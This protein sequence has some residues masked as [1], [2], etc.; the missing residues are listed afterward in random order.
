MK[1]FM[2]LFLT[3]ICIVSLVACGKKEENV[4]VNKEGTIYEVGKDITFYYPS[5]FELTSTAEN[6]SDHN[7]VVFKKENQVLFYEVINDAYDNEVSQKIELYKGELEVLGARIDEVKEPALE[8]GL[9]C[10]EYIGEYPKTG[11]KFTHLVYF[12][13]QYTYVYGYEAN[14]KEYNDNID[15]IIVYLET[16]TK[17]TGL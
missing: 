2:K 7:T 13:S 10:Y 4:Q 16:F 3:M 8:S 17:S 1:K 14:E 12:D 15:Q 6:D 11:L 9:K 5:D